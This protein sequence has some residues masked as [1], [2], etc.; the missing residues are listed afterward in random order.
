MIFL[1]KPSNFRFHAN[2]GNFLSDQNAARE[3]SQ[4]VRVSYIPENAR[5]IQVLK[6]GWCRWN[7]L[8]PWNSIFIPD[9]SKWC[10]GKGNFFLDVPMFDDIWYLCCPHFWCTPGYC[11]Y[12][13]LQVGRFTQL[14][15]L[16]EN[17]H[18]GGIVWKVGY[19][20]SKFSPAWICYPVD[21][22]NFWW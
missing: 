21:V 4:I 16:Y 6:L 5:T 1:F 14:G 10:F 13:H 20:S 8:R 12:T 19:H 3:F 18:L 15:G 9:T 2:F 7:L 22:L 17:T 11:S